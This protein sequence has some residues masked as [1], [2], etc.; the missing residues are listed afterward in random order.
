MRYDKDEER[1]GEMLELKLH[2]RSK[3]SHSHFVRIETSKLMHYS[4][5]TAAEELSL[6]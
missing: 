5:N 6:S 1:E 4:I 2:F 3:V